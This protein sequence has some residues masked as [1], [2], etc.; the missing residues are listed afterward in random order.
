MDPRHLRSSSPG[1]RRLHQPGRSSTGTITYPQDYDPYYAPTRSSRESI[2]APRT[3][4]DRLLAPNTTIRQYRV[5][6]G[7][8]RRVD[9]YPVSPRRATLDPLAAAGRRPLGIVPVSSPNRYHPVI[10]SATEKP[11]SPFKPRPR[12]EEPHY[13]LPASSALSRRE[14]HRTYSADNTADHGR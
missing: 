3:S 14:H 9:D 4:A 8:A 2:S 11:S 13:S 6:G 7:S 12:D 5:D 10:S 1:S